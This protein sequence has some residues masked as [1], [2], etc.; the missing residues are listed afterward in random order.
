MKFIEFIKELDKFDSDT[1][2]Q[3]CEKFN[4]NSDNDTK[5]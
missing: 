5:I 1:D 3:G 4:S 2:N